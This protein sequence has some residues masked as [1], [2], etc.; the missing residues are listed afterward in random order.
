MLL[1]GVHTH[2]ITAPSGWA[3][4]RHPQRPL[5]PFAFLAAPIPGPSRASGLMWP[6]FEG[7]VKGRTRPRA[8]T[9]FVGSAQVFEI[10]LH[11]CLLLFTV[12]F[13]VVLLD[14]H[15]IVFMHSPADGHLGFSSY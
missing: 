14:E 4:S 5:C 2:A 10:Q 3:C 15:T 7:P 12:V 8:V 13:I 1:T 11:C 9:A 6:V